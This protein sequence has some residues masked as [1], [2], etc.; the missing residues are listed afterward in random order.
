MPWGDRSPEN[1]DYDGVSVEVEI[2][3]ERVKEGMIVRSRDVVSVV[4]NRHIDEFIGEVDS[5]DSPCAGT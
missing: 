4:I 5:D 2:D 3:D 1:R